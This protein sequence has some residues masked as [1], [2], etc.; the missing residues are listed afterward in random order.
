M[1]IINEDEKLTNKEIL[2]INPDIQP[3]EADNN[4]NEYGDLA[5]SVTTDINQEITPNKKYLNSE[6]NLNS[7]WIFWF[8][9]RKE[10]DHKI[11]YSDRLKKIAEFC[12][13]EKFFK[14]YMF[15]KSPSD[16]ERNTEL[17]LFKE[18]FKPLWES[19]L[20]SGCWFI[21]YKKNDDPYE[22]DLKW[23]KLVFA[24]IGKIYIK[25]KVNNLKMT[26]FWV[27]F[28]R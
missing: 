18:G 2:S 27:R 11:P 4:K 13:I 24:L 7:I 8:L 1:N 28:Y 17:S 22:L 21:R 20:G 5:Y 12:T 9:S 25:N 19:C 16:M 26:I 6:N 23:E 15:I 10:K 14:F 3:T